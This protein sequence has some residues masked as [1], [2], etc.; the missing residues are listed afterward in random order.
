MSSAADSSRSSSLALS[1]AMA[2]LNAEL[3]NRFAP[4]EFADWLVM[5][6]PLL[7]GCA[8]LD[9][10][11]EGLEGYRQVARIDHFVRHG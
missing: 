2:V 3:G 8:P 1:I 10:L 7:G 11:P 5:P 4:D 9:L 6:H